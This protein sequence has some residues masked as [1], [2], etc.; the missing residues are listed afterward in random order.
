MNHLPQPPVLLA[1]AASPTDIATHLADLAARQGEA[2]ALHLLDDPRAGERTVSYAALDARARAFAARLADHAEPGARVLLLLETGLDYVGAFFGCLYAGLIAVPAFPPEANRPQHQARLAS[3]ARDCGASVALIHANDRSAAESLLAAQPGTAVLCVE[4]VEDGDSDGFAMR[5]SRPSDIAFLQYTSGSTSTPKGVMVSHGNLISN[6]IAIR[7]GFSIDP[8]KTILSWLP[9]YHDM[10]LIGG[11]LQPLFNGGACILMS[12]R[13]FLARPVRWLEALSRFRSEVSGGPDFAYRMCVER[14]DPAQ[15]EGLD[16]S[17]W[18]VAYSGSEPVR[19]STMEA[20]AARFAPLG[21]DARAVHP[22]YGLAEATLFV[23][24]QRRGEGLMAPGF[25]APRLAAGEAQP[26]EGPEAVRVVACGV[27]AAD[28][29]VRILDPATGAPMADGRVGDVVA[30]GPSIAQ[31]YWNNPAAT[32]ATFPDIGGVRMLRTGDLGFL[33]GGQLYL[34]GRAKDLIIIRGQNLYPHDIEEVIEREVDLVRQGRIAAFP[35]AC[36]DGE[37]IGI[38]VEISRRTRKTASA[39]SIAALVSEVV[40]DAFLEPARVVV[41]LEPGALPRTSSGKLQRSAVARGYGDN[42]LD[43]FAILRDG[44]LE[45][46]AGA[47][48]SVSAPVAPAPAASAMAEKLAVIWSEVLGRQ[49]ITAD[50]HFFALGGNSVEA[51]RVRARLA[52]LGLDVPV[53]ELFRHPTLGRLAAALEQIEAAAPELAAPVTTPDG[54]AP[55]TPAQR[56]M[57][58]LSEVAAGAASRAAYH[59]AGGIRFPAPVDPDAL[60]HALTDLVARHGALRTR[61]LRTEVGDAVQEELAADLPLAVADL[62][63][64]ADGAA[65]AA[66]AK[67][68]AEAPFDLAAAPLAR[69]LLVRRPDGQD[70]LLVTLHHLICDGWSLDL[71]SEELSAAYAARAAGSAPALPP[72]GSYLAYAHRQAAEAPDEAGLA[73]WRARLTDAPALTTLPAD[74]PRPAEASHRGGRLEITFDPAL[75]ANL[76]ALAASADATLPI[77]LIALFN[78]LLH[79]LSGADDL[80]VGLAFANRAA[81]GDHETM[82]LFVNTLPVRLR[83]DGAAAFGEVLRRAR[84]GVVEAQAHQHVPLDRVLDALGTARSLSRHPLFQTLYTHLPRR[85]GARVDAF[86]RDSGGQQ[87]DLALET[88]ETADGGLVLAFGYAL[89]LFEPAT[90]GRFAE[91]FATLGRAAVAAPDTRLDLLALV[92]KAALAAHA[93]PWP[94]QSALPDVPVPDLIALQAQLRPDAPA[95]IFGDTVT[96]FATLEA[97]ANRLAHVLV[98]QGVGPET[99]VGVGLPRG[100]DL[101]AALLAVWK[102]GGA[103]VPFDP[104]HPAERIA[105]ILA[106][107]G[108][109]LVLAR[110]GVAPGVPNL[111]PERLDLSSQ[112]ASPVGRTT[113]PDQL[114]YL[115]YTSGSTG[116]PKGVMVAHGA[117]SGHCRATGALYETSERTREFHFLSMSFDGAHERWMVPLIHGGA[118]ILTDRTPWATAD[119]LDTLT[120]HHATHGGFPPAYLDALAETAQARGEAPGVD[121]LSF[122]GEAMPAESFARI[123]GALKPRLLINGYGPTE[124]VISPLAWKV[125]AATVLDTPHVPIGRAVGMRR[126]YV[127]DGALN[128]LP[129]GVPGELYV[130]GEGLARGYQGMPGA[131]AERFL[132]DPF[133]PPGG[134]MYR[135]GDRAR[136]RA[137]GTAEYLGRT[138]RQIKLRGFRIEP[139][140]VEAA[141][142]ALPDVGA[143]AVALKTMGASAQLVGYVVATAGTVPDPTALRE[144]LTRRLPDHMVP[145]RLMV[146]DALP[147]TPN[148]KVDY[149]ALPV[150]ERPAPAPESRPPQTEDERLLALVWAEVLRL[151][152][153]PDL[154]ANFFE[155]GGDSI[156]SLQ[157]VARARRAGLVLSARDLFEHQT[158]ARLAGAARREETPAAP[159]APR[160]P[161]PLT[162]L[163]RAFLDSGAPRLHHFNQTLVLSPTRPLDAAH[164]AAAIDHVTR[165]HGALHLRFTRRPDGNWRQEEAEVATTP[166]LAVV[167]AADSAAAATLFAALESAL[168]IAAGPL[169]RALLANLED[170]AQQL[171]LTA[172]HLVVDAVSWRIL[173][174]EIE[175]TYLGLEQGRPLASPD[176]GTPFAVRTTHRP[177]STGPVVATALPCDHPDGPNTFAHRRVPRLAVDATQVEALRQ[178]ALAHHARLDDLLLAAVVRATGRLRGLPQ[179]TVGIEGHGRDLVPGAD[180]SRTVGWFT[181]LSM[182]ALPLEDDLRRALLA[183]KEAAR[184][185]VADAEAPPPGLIFNHLGRVDAG[186]GSSLFALDAMDLSTD[187]DLPL[188]AELIVDASETEAGA[189]LRLTTSAARW[190]EAT[191][192]RLN[193]AIAADLARM[194]ILDGDGASP[195]DF[196]LAGLAQS[197]LDRLAL[198]W[199]EIEDLYPLTPTQQGILFHALEGSGEGAYVNQLRV[200]IAG[201]DAQRFAAAWAR[202]VARHDILRSAFLWTADLGAPLQAVRRHVPFGVQHHPPMDA[203]DTAALDAIA[204]DDRARGFALDAAP[205]MRVRLVPLGSE[206]HHFIWTAHHLL[207]DGWSSARLMAEVLA[208]YADAPMPPPPARF[209]DH[210]AALATPRGDGEAF[211]RTRLAQLEEPSLLAATTTGPAVHRHL[212]VPLAAERWDRL[213]TAAKA[214]RVTLASLFQAAWAL[215]LKHMTGRPA[216]AFGTTVSGRPDDDPRM[217]SVLGLFIATVPTILTVPGSGQAADFVRHVQAESVATTAHA[218]TPLVD[219]LRW[220]GRSGQALFD[221][222][223]VFE[224]YPMDAAL[225]ARTVDGLAFGPVVSQEAT[226]FP[227]TLSVITDAEP[228]LAWSYDAARFSPAAMEQLSSRLLLA[229][230][231]L[232]GQPEADLSALSLALPQEIAAA[233]AHGIAAAPVAELSPVHELIAAQARLRPDAIAVTCG[234]DA[235]TYGDLDRHAERLA[236]RLAD[237]GVGPGDIVGISAERAPALIAG[238]LAILK[239]GAAYLPLDPIYPQARRAYMIGDAGVR[240]ILADTTNAADLPQTGLRHIP[241]DLYGEAEEDAAAMRHWPSPHPDQPAYV[242]YTSGSTGAPKGVVVNHG[243]VARLLTATAPWF[244]FGPDDVWTLFHAYGFDFS[245]WEIFGA[246]SFGGR[247]VVVPQAV[248]RAPEEVLDLVVR[249]RVTVLNQTPSAFRPFLQAALARAEKPDLALRHVIFGGEALDVGVLGPWY[250]RFGIKARLVNMYGITETT[251]HVTYRPLGPGDVAGASRSPIGGPIPDLTLHLLDDLLDPVPIGVPGELCVGGAGLASGYLKRPGLTA[252]RFVPDPFGPPGSR[253]YLSGDK[254]VR[255]PDGTLDYLGRGDGQVKIRGFR[256]ELGEIEARL[257][258]DAAVTDAAVV[259]RELPG[260]PALVAY[261]VAGGPVDPAAVRARL[262]AGLPDYMVPA[263]VVALNVLPLTANGKLDRAA[264]PEP[265]ATAITSAP[266]EGADEEALAAIWRDVLGAGEIGREDNFFALGGHS[267]SATQV[268][269]EIRERLGVE[270]PVRRLFECQTLRSLALVLA[271]TRDTGAP[272]TESAPGQ[273]LGADALAQMDALLGELEG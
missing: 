232:A 95:V 135:T 65:Y 5:R 143:A 228:R 101:I 120:R 188:G 256:I 112:P 114:A 163:Q 74:H 231:L 99:R 115:V 227:L 189:E 136:W 97:E 176:P 107:A 102:A 22:C 81:A 24:A 245:V 27:P 119:T 257:R 59:V 92:D 68:H 78:V 251:V 34:A 94:D 215:V 268:R 160:G 63:D 181:A 15:A 146:L 233:R 50:S 240:C 126:A 196:P 33:S 54:P 118:I 264:L 175:S 252:A 150:P 247:L 208:D 58:F 53:A 217:E 117:L 39:E 77:A 28:H 205:L 254:A 89:D 249:E 200:T 72:T 141:L 1:S 243:N 144:A 138:D 25:D 32:A 17:S 272:A 21:F 45:D 2:L 262:Q 269:L 190:D 134:R 159:A 219:I 10:G 8:E 263:H 266:P 152:E 18:K 6:E 222:L 104:D 210:V 169:F 224:N 195:S 214:Q 42:T 130:A 250:E 248:S 87:F 55:L 194:A 62:G 168:D 220:A 43:A 151:P 171:F 82:G 161:L 13:H 270:V 158:I 73:F 142:R 258:D 226:N 206:A 49:D 26:G 177:A 201:L 100:P 133:G 29:G 236:R 140:E 127:L 61:F 85:A 234:A 182:A 80:C 122:G 192:A 83:V 47:T 86:T 153:D 108:T 154:D 30:F 41:L 207:L 48:A 66:L 271:E 265:R 185:A 11:L 167:A 103:F 139:G 178:V 131:T 35:V 16:L 3:M 76:R 109:K 14:I 148:G 157:I 267:L 145:A 4:D 69:A 46:R 60:A 128:P 166:P 239:T 213:G 37:G 52:A 91:A 193:E 56:R 137:D 164:L 67:T 218:D 259:V 197:A 20:F 183:T 191:L 64:D 38:A 156:L 124:A 155:L 173:L 204:Q 221:S 241:L 179:L 98:A 255:R 36:N 225:K 253:L 246:L 260:G 216:V 223:L 198:P 40:G 199:R 238:L 113:H 184:R 19:A 244:G 230:D 123:A 170:G 180:F 186:R 229:L 88:T 106:D 75:T 174:D 202:A 121:I 23:T 84:D 90:V 147:L 209:R 7:A 111:D 79:R 132:P 203:A 273:A 51:M 242:I 70:E 165:Q 57:W 187:P 31:G 235:L 71:L 261:V 116:R 105:H 96:S 212:T 12:P 110:E 129:V 162:P 93:A 44:V 211:W 172:H 9:L 125:P 237:A 149:A